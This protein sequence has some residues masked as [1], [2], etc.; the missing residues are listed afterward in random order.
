MSEVTLTVE[1]RAGHEREETWELLEIF[2]PECGE[3]R[4]WREMSDGDYYVGP[5]YL[6][7]ACGGGGQILFCGSPDIVHD[8]HESTDEQRLT[9]IR[10]ATGGADERG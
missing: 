1:Y 5:S 9:A 3:K 6:C 8:L 7:A 2:C 10:K 4:V